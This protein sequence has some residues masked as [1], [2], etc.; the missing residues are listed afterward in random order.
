MVPGDV[1]E[2][3]TVE[4][5]LPG[6]GGL[7]EQLVEATPDFA[8]LVL[9]G[10]GRIC[11]WPP[12]ARDLYGWSAEEAL[13]MHFSRFYAPEE[14]RAGR[15]EAELR[16]AASQGRYEEEGW[17]YRKDGR[18]F[19]ANVAVVAL[20]GK[21][22]QLLGY[23]KITR[24]LTEQ[25]KARDEIRRMALVIETAAIPVVPVWQGV[26][27]VPLI[28]AL[29][30]SRTQH[31]ME[32]LLQVVADSRSPVAVIDITG[33]PTVDSQIAQHLIETV[34]AVRLLGADVIMTGIRAG[35][36]QTLVHLGIDLSG[37]TTRSSLVDG[38]GL[39]LERLG[40]QVV[41]HPAGPRGGLP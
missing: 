4:P 16:T 20:R 27:L 14:A 28:G 22:G 10:Q 19:W 32:R 38:L 2:N 36:A 30:S 13:G 26:V 18:P 17:R 3:R 5:A 21:D 33:V 41:P 24:D 7:L 25:R 34:S 23:G 9:D 12:A 40:L 1:P 29:D 37:I 31:L 39:A 11:N 6:S 35:I 8:I 15:P